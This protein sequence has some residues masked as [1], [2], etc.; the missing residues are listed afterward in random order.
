MQTPYKKSNFMMFSTLVGLLMTS[1]VWGAGFQI[2]EQ[3]I[4]N[5]GTA[6][7]GTAALAADA[8]TAHY[9]PAGITRI[10]GRQLVISGA[11]IDADSDFNPSFATNMGGDALPLRG[12][13]DFGTMAA[14][15]SLHYTAQIND[16]VYFGLSVTA[17]FG[18]AT[19]Y[20]ENSV[21]RYVSTRSELKTV[22][23]SPSIAYHFNDKFSFAAGFD[24][25]YAKAHLDLQ[26]S[27]PTPGTIIFSDGFQRNTADDWGWGYHLAMLWEIT[28]STRLGLNYRSHVNIKA[29][30]ESEQMSSVTSQADIPNFFTNGLRSNFPGG[31]NVVLP[32]TLYVSAYHAFTENFAI[33]T[34]VNWTAWSRFKTLRLRYDAP[35]PGVSDA[36][37]TPTDTLENWKDTFRIA[38]GAEYTL[39]DKYKFRIGAAWDESPVKTEFR[40]ARVPDSDRIWLGL[41]FGFALSQNLWVDLGYAHLFFDDAEMTDKGP[42]GAGGTFPVTRVQVTGKYNSNVNIFGAQFRWTLS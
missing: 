41:G 32:E 35:L 37:R 7:A 2:Q 10:P 6:Y 13:E 29:R 8:S 22:D 3:N 28:E 16:K 20:S 18:L 12:E 34:D 33:M 39:S 42:F 15:P 14:V 24:A 4:T 36:N 9:N 5:L 25:L 26:T 11:I 1:K 23:V 40:T 27:F 21:A 19:E 38:L 17:P 30:G 31:A